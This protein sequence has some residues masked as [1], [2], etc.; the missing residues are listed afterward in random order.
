MDAVPFSSKNPPVVLRAS[1]SHIDWGYEP[2]YDCVCA[3]S[4]KSR[5]ALD[6][7]RELLLYPYGCAKL[8]M[9]ELP[10]VQEKKK[11]S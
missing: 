2:R 8:R 1:L 9:T 3:K 7:P 5:V 4:P 6:E 10:M 11:N